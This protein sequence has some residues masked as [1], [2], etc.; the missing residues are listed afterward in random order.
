MTEMDVQTLHGWIDGGRDFDLVDTLPPTAFEKAHLPGAINIVS[1]EILAR[2]P[3]E[4]PDK[5]RN[6]VVYCASAKCKRAG[7]SA[8]RLERLGYRRVHHF[9]GGKRA[10]REAGFALTGTEAAAHGA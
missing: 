7:L 1:D 5:A 8:E 10:W 2:A 3:R 6:V 4:V 9:V